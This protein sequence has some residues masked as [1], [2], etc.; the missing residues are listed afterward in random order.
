M[1][2]VMPE[3]IPVVESWLAASG[4]DDPP[5]TS[6]IYLRPRAT[7]LR[8]QE[9]AWHP[10]SDVFETESAYHVRVELAGMEKEEICV[11]AESG[12]L[13]ISGF[14]AD[15]STREKIRYRQM[16]IKYGTFEVRFRLPND[17]DLEAVEAVY[18][19]G[20]LETRLPKKQQHQTQVSKVTIYI[21]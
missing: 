9:P 14:R 16:E 13:T 18:A 21:G 19:N 6:E 12:I 17:I 15:N 5:P 8:V 20:F 10:P 2:V 11:V 7:L 4:E 3:L 1:N